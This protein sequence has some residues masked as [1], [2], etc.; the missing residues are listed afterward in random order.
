MITEKSESLKVR[1]KLILRL[2]KYSDRYD[3]LKLRNHE[4]TRPYM[5]NEEVIKVSE[6][7]DWFARALFSSDVF[8]FVA[9]TDEPAIVGSLVAKKE[10]DG[11]W[12]LSYITHPCY[13]GI[14]VAT[15]MLTNVRKM[16]KPCRA[17]IKKTNIVSIK[18]ALKAGM[19]HELTQNGV[20]NFV[21]G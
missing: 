13:R 18:T 21:S 17:R 10:E 11:F 12:D 8:I 4:G 1:R 19:E 2:A 14:G 6:H 15:F 9:E 3:I 5:F 7:V 20:V 16:C